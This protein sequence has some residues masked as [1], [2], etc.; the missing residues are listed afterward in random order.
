MPPIDRQSYSDPSVLERELNSIFLERLFV[1]T[2]FDYE[3]EQSYRSMT[4]G[5]RAFTVRRC[6]DDVRAL[7]NVCLHRNA[8]IDPPG[9]GERPFRCRYHG[10]RYAAD[11]TLAEAPLAED[12]CIQIR[13]LPRFP[14]TESCGLYFLGLSG[15]EPGIDEVSNALARFDIRIQRPFHR[16]ALTHS[17]NWKLLVENVLEGYHL[18]F[19]HGDTFRP[20]GFTSAGNYSW[21]GGSHSSWNELTPTASR[22]KQSAMKRL[23]LDAGHYYRH[24][25]IFPDLFVSNTN[26]LVGF[27]SHVVPVDS[28]TT[29][30]EWELFE[31]PALEALPATVREQVKAEA[32][33]FTEQALR[34]DQVLVESC[35]TGLACIGTQVQLQPCEGRIGHFHE[36]YADRMQHD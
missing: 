31:L 23:S 26:G 29:R 11:G 34:E 16:G 17:C 9:Q 10:W 3:A 30:L 2:R 21:G 32:V 24:V 1:G 4:L 6:G 13:T 22:D 8:L 27:L 20:A 18:S 12:A 33:R 35:Q 36:L 25:Y 5:R 19:V 7:G 15:K 14:V 28:S